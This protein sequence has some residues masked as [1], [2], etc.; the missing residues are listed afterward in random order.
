MQEIQGL[1]SAEAAA[2]MAD[3][4]GG[5][6][7]PAITKT[8]GQIVRENVCT[9]FNLLNFTIAVMLFCVHAYS[10]MAF[11]A[12]IILNIVLGIAQEL[13]AKKLVDELSIL[14]R[15]RAVI[16][17]D[18]KQT[19]MPA[20]AVVLDDVMVLES[21]RQICN[22]SVVISGT[23]EVNESLLTG[24]SDAIV[25]HAGDTLLSGSSVISGKCYA[26]VTHVG[27]KNYAA[28]LTA[29]V[30]QEKKTAS[31]LLGSM[32]KVTGFTSWLIVPLGV[33]LLAEALLL[34]G[35]PVQDAVVSSAAALLGMLPKGL[36][37]LI[38]VSLAMGVTRLAKRKILVQNL[39]ALET[40]AHV[41]TLCLDKTGTITDGRLTLSDTLFLQPNGI[42]QQ[43]AQ[44][45][46]QGYLA[47][48][49]DNNATASAL[50]KSYP[51]QSMGT[52]VGKT[53]FS[54]ARKWGAV[55]LEGAGTV[56]LGAPERLL[57]HTLPQ[58]EAAL[59]NGS[60]VLAAAWYPGSWLDDT[61]LPPT[62][63]LRPLYLFTLTDTIR[64]RT[65]ETLAW[66][67]K[68]GV[69]VK[70]IS[71]D[72]VKTV[73]QIARRAGLAKWQNAIDLSTV[74]EDAD[75]AALCDQYTVFARV[76]PRQ[77]Q[78]LVQALQQQG[79]KVAM[80]GDG[81]NDLLA[82]R[83]ADC[84]I[85][86]AEGSD[87]SRQLAQIVLLESDF[88]HLPQVVKEGRRVIHNVTR[89]AG[90]FFIK[91]IYSLLLSVF[92]LAANFPFPFIPIQITLID[93]CIEAFPSFASIFEA[94]LRPVRG[95]F[96]P[97]ALGNAAPFAFVVTATILFTTLFTPLAGGTLQTVQYLLLVVFSLA[98]VIKS[99]IP[100]TPLRAAIC[101]LA[102]GGMAVAM[103][104]FHNLLELSA[105]DNMAILTWALAAAMGA[106][107]LYLLLQL[108]R[109]VKSEA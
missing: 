75:Y 33:A 4:R 84:S 52:T 1:T 11:I 67:A 49:D 98:A 2:R 93:A 107:I 88:T 106:M 17:R 20:E 25:K 51:P 78:Q 105:L 97:T 29:E 14:N 74:G 32:R 66:F 16:L 80:T 81:V 39:Y 5:A 47:A 13:K 58:E 41:D 60:R 94:D 38:S 69:E 57:A 87:A 99:C 24:E 22:D 46:L 73:A 31:E 42:A 102:T 59:Q 37:L 40:L 7:P 6:V 27:S 48:T 56:F 77:K 21:G 55:A 3:G 53:A 43:D 63:E 18:G 15:P 68:Q 64:P 72:H 36:V 76:T 10:N 82:L 90:V 101:T 108:Q 71:G 44:R 83:E 109:A 35:A 34:R 23:V 92:C 89:T 12:I 65:K 61:A 54:S 79:H 86:V 26:R 91:T 19:E 50:K 8:R 9:L 70:V 104:L 95:K 30:K 96:L 103:V 62:A 85:A 45:L 100:F 28:A